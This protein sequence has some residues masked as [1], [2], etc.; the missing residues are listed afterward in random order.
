VFVFAIIFIEM[1]PQNLLLYYLKGDYSDNATILEA[2]YIYIFF[3]INILY[4]WLTI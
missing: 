2:I 3:Y 4:R 1:F